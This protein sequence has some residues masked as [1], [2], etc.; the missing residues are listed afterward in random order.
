MSSQ[1]VPVPPVKPVR[2][3]QS[4]DTQASVAAQARP[5]VPQFVAS[6]A[7][8][9]QA[10]PQAVAAPGHTQAFVMTLQL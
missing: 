8:F 6:V 2:G 1:V 4:P 3:V 7:R 9:T 5:H 10:V